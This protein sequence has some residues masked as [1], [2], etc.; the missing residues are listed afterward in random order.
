MRVEAEST[1][2]GD[3]KGEYYRFIEIFKWISFLAW[4]KTITLP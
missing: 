3:F 4:M 2:E 1:V